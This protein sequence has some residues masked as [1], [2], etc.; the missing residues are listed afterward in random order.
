[1][2]AWRAAPLPTAMVGRRHR[3]RLCREGLGDQ[4]LSNIYYDLFDCR[5]FRSLNV[6]FSVI[7]EMAAEVERRRIAN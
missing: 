2:T 4:K 5:F 6:Y 3:G 7:D 1:M